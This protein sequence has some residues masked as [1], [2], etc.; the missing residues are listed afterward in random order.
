MRPLPFLGKEKMLHGTNIDNAWSTSFHGSG[1]K[2]RE[3]FPK[4]ILL[5]YC[6]TIKAL[7]HN[8]DPLKWTFAIQVDYSHEPKTHP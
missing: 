2:S 8:I 6:A 1:E 3:W 7:H 5:I 4:L